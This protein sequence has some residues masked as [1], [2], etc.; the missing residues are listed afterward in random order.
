[1][2][3]GFLVREMTVGNTCRMQLVVNTNRAEENMGKMGKKLLV[4]ISLGLG[5]AT[6]VTS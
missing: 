6:M 2:D 4:G 3:M 1:M 5:T